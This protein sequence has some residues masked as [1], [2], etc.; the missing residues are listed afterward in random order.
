[1]LEDNEQVINVLKLFSESINAVV[2]ITEE[3]HETIER[4]RDA[5]NAG[6]PYDII[7][8]D[9]TIPGGMGGG[10]VM[11]EILA[12][13]PYACGIVSSG[14]SEVPIMSSHRDHGFCTVLNKP[15]T[16]EGFKTAILEALNAKKDRSGG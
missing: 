1:V 11:K 12:F 16:Y 2:D 5:Y 4:Y 15:F 14:Y 7:L 3:G 10:E 6:N 9:L 8:T 13:D